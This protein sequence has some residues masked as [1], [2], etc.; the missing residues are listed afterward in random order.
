[1]VSL[2]S[3][4][5]LAELFQLTSKRIPKT[6]YLKLIDIWFTSLCVF[7]FFM[8]LNVVIIE[9]YRLN[10]VKYLYESQNLPKKLKENEDDK[11]EIAANL[12]KKNLFLA[13]RWNKICLIAYPS[14]V[15]VFLMVVAV[16]ANKRFLYNDD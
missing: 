12:A 15:L 4:L 10:S 16:L 7:N 2:T 14:S 3:Q 9:V 11:S 6:A 1:M 5:V 8:V 13:M